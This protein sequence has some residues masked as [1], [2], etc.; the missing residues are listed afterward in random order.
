[1]FSE[2]MLTW[3]GVT[4][5]VVPDRPKMQLS[6]DCPVTDD[7]RADTNAWMIRFFGMVN[8]MKD[9]EVIEVNFDAVGIGGGRRLMCN[10]RT[11]AKIEP[12]VRLAERQA[13]VEWRDRRINGWG[14]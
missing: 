4:F 2:N 10:P 6:A 13:M 3:N 14:F 5:Q 11:Y 8:P 9:D 12:M 1:M 7:Y